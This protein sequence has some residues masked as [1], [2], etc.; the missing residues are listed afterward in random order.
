[1]KV[2]NIFKKYDNTKGYAP[3]T[4]ADLDTGEINKLGWTAKVNL[5]EMFKRL[6]NYLKN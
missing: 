5:N 3:D 6:I 1:M 4:L 2:K